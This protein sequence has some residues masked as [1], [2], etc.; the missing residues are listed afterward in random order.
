M[1]LNSYLI[2]N[3]QCEAAFK[4]YEQCLGGKI[5]T[6]MTHAE[7]PDSEMA[8]VPPEWRDKILHVGLMVGNQELMGSD[9]LPDYYEKPQGFSV[10][11]GIDDPAKAERIF[12][13]LAENGKVQMPLQQTFWAY[14]FGMLVDQFSIPWMI[15][16]E[17]VAE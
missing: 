1:Q 13:A 8:Q 10:S 7:S 4:F 9:S 17:V 11:I 16:C 5:T 2:F 6:M 3:G 14:R 15:N 12:N